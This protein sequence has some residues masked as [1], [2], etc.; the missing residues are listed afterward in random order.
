MLPGFWLFGAGVRI[1]FGEDDEPW[2]QDALE[3]HPDMIHYQRQLCCQLFTRREKAM[4]LL[5]GGVG[6]AA[7]RG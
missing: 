6:G 7:G 2:W 5:G 3:S 4:Q 1:P